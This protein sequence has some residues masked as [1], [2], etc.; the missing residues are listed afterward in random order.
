MNSAQLQLKGC[1]VGMMNP[2]YSQG[3]KENSDLYELSF[4]E[5]LLNSLV[6]GGK[7]I[8]IIPQSSMNGKTNIEK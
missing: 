3:S 5:H 2:P 6:E 1:N 7:G 8:V 4:T